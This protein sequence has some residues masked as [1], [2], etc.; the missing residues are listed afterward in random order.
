M[1]SELNDATYNGRM[2]AKSGGVAAAVINNV[3]GL[4]VETTS[5]QGLTACLSSLKSSARNLKEGQ[6]LFMECMSCEGDCVGG[7]GTL[8]T[9]AAAV[10]A[11]EK[12][13][14]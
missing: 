13:T 7:P 3:G 8:V 4:P 9:A 12:H 5:V 1:E 11:L 10:R 14:K 2:F 6:F